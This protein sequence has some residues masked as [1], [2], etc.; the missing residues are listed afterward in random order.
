MIYVYVMIIWGNV[1]I[2]VPIMEQ[3][4]WAIGQEL[5]IFVNNYKNI[6]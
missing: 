4:I 5:A 2:N 3:G 1:V 6:I